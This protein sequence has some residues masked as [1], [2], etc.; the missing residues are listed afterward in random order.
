MSVVFLKRRRGDRFF[1]LPERRRNFAIAQMERQA[2]EELP[3]QGIFCLSAL[4]RKRVLFTPADVVRYL[5]TEQLSSN[6]SFLSV[7][8]HNACGGFFLEEKT[9]I[10]MDLLVIPLAA[11]A[12]RHL[13]IRDLSLVAAWR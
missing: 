7:A 12:L 1:L 3:P 4:V 2:E 8:N 6:S 13:F 9:I 5:S 10:F 11:A